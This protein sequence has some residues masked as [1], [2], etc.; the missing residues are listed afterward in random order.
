MTTINLSKEDLWHSVLGGAALSTG[1]GGSAPSYEGFCQAVDPVFDAGM[2]PKLMDPMDLADDDLVL[3]PIGIGGGIPREDRERY[4]PPV[5]RGPYMDVALKEMD[6][7]FPLLE[8]GESQIGNW[9]EA[10]IERLKEVKGE[11]DYAVYFPGEIGPGIYRQALS[12]ARDG[13]PVVDADCAGQRAVPELSFT[14]FNAM[15]V[16]AGPVVIATVWGDLLVYEKN[17]SWQRLEDITR[18]I[19]LVSGG[20][21]STVFSLDGKAIKEASVHGSY[22][23]A[24]RVGEAIQEARESG[25]DPV[26]KIVEATGGYKLFEGEVVSYTQEGKF[27]FI[28]GN[29]WIK[30]TGDFDGKLFRYW[31][32]N[33]NQVS[34]LD[35][36]PYVTCPDPFTVIDA[37]TGDGLANFRSENWVPGRKVAVVG[38]RAVD[39]WRTE[40]GLS[41][42]NPRH[43]GFHIKY[44]PIEKIM[45]K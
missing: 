29:G 35:D 5:R 17:I 42:Y 11:D 43:F 31:Y 27:A 19:A 9:R 22:S 4:G 39:V 12:G 8:G 37:E 40:R 2:T 34:W 28:W 44:K 25:D 38:V 14:S 36:E 18:A 15:N 6:R 16:P 3:V 24:I 30:G 10:A 20:F 32:K 23:K 1:G 41:I 26:S 7:V 45:E 13:V 21:N 33:E